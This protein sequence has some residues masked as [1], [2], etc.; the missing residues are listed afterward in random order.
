[1]TKAGKLLGGFVRLDDYVNTHGFNTS[2]YGS[3]RDNFPNAACQPQ[4]FQP[5]TCLISCLTGIALLNMPD[6]SMLQVAARQGSSEAQFQLA[7]RFDNAEGVPRDPVA[8]ANWYRFAAEQRHA[9]AQFHL[10]LM[11]HAGD[12]GLA[13]DDRA[14]ANWFARAAE[15]GLADAQFNL[16]LMYY[17]A[18]GVEQSDTLAR[19][20]FHAAAEQGHAKAQF[21]LGALYANGQGVEQNYPEAYKLWLLAIMQGDANAHAN[22]AMLRGKL[23][24][25]EAVIAQAEAV[26]WTNARLTR[27]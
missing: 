12:V 24:D 1:M 2:E 6:I 16:G 11:L 23:T 15:Q 7:L 22:I 21:N 17:N 19:N 25:E 13:R 18:E 4:L 3:D 26:D 27:S 5:G 14:A 8:A 10:G 9:L 20:W